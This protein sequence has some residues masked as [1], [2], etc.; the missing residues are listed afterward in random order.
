MLVSLKPFTHERRMTK[1]TTR[2]GNVELRKQKVSFSDLPVGGG[3][4]R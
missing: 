3:Q 4:G 1:E 2:E